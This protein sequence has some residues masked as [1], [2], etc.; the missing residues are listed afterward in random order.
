[1]EQPPRSTHHDDVISLVDLA[2]VLIHRRWWFI[3][4]FV[5]V[6]LASLGWVLLKKTENQNGE[7]T[8]QYTTQLAV[9]YKTAK[10]LIEPLISIEE[11]LNG[12]IIPT[13]RQKSDEF[14]GLTANVKY[15][16]GSNIIT[17]ITQGG[18][19]ESS[20]VQDFH[21]ALV[22]PIVERHDRML[23]SLGQLRSTLFQE[24]NTEQQ[25]IPSE[26]ISL[27]V[28]TDSENF[29]HEFNGKLIIILGIVLGG[30]AGVMAA[31]VAEFSARVLNSLQEE[32]NKKAKK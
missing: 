4:T 24:Y 28:K 14:T 27:A 7:Q 11:Q 3:G 6:V 21:Q 31:F 19:E 12:A 15:I 1:M 26:R 20:A 17:L 29:S 18:E 10:E 13:V 22:A 2:K 16:D 32:S 5:I 23:S 9:G 25:L 8:Y 30:I